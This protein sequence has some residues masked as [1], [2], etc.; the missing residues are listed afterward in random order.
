M[1]GM[2]KLADAEVQAALGTLPGWAR[3]GDEIAKTYEC[4]SFPEAVAFV[5]RVGFVAEKT[6][7]HPDIDVRWRKVRI[8]L[9]THDAGSLTNLDLDM[10]RSIEALAP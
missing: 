4:A 5:V 2:D 6:N 7:H 10:A 8:T 1:E 9:T 3:D